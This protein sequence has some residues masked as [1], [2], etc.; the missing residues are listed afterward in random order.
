MHDRSFISQGLHGT[1]RR[2]IVLHADATR[3]FAALEDDFHHMYVDIAHD[4]RNV[5][6]ITGKTLRIP[7]STCPG[8]VQKLLDLKRRPLSESYG[9]IDARQQCT[10]LF[11]IARLAMTN[12]LRQGRRQYDLSIPD[13]VDRKSRPELRR[14]GRT[15]LE[16]EVDGRFIT[17]PAPYAGS[18]LF[19]KADWKHFDPETLEAAMI[20]RRAVW[21][22][23]GRR[24]TAAERQAREQGVPV[25]ALHIMPTSLMGA[26]Y[27]H[28]PEIYSAGSRI[29]DFTYDFT[30][31]PEELLAE[32][33]T[34][35]GGI[36]P[37][38]FTT[39][40]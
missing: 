33:A 7:R 22:S 8:A 40:A 6:E 36:P 29:D 19:G 30:A 31:H 17:G 15:V 16:W 12:A 1:Y 37:S 23:Y 35:E 13:P 32:L 26:C 20:L 10:H 3:T 34:F 14:D 27:S 2:R 18:E 24:G 11:D 38:L 39:L 5:L 4:G 28:Q 21:I 25:E 9:G